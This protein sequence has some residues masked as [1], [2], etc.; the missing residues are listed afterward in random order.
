MRQ[1]YKQ[2]LFL[3]FTIR[4]ILI[5][6]QMTLSRKNSFHYQ[7]CFIKIQESWSHLYSFEK[8][9]FFEH[10]N[11]LG[12]IQTNIHKFLSVNFLIRSIKFERLYLFFWK[13]P[14]KRSSTGYK[15][16]FKD[17][18]FSRNSVIQIIAFSWKSTKSFQIHSI[19]CSKN[20]QICMD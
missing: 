20:C 17:T 3:F 18:S 4:V 8:S 10:E 13:S 2:Q 11:I 1:Y 14:L 7:H 19:N 16:F 12:E 5:F 15:R 6:S 9:R